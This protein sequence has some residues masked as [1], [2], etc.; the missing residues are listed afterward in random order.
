MLK[1]AHENRTLAL[2]F[3]IVG[4]ETIRKTEIFL[5]FLFLCMYIVTM[6]AH[7][8]IIGLVILDHQLHKPMYM[9][10]ANFSVAEIFYISTTMP[11]MLDA[12]L[13][14]N[15]EISY[16]GCIAQFY[17]FFSFG[18]TEHCF[19]VVMGYDRYVAICHPLHYYSMMAK[20]IS[21]G[22]A[23]GAWT[24]GLLAAAAPALWVSSLNFC[25]PNL[26]DHF[27]CDYAPLLKLSCEDT[28]KGEFTFT[29]IS[30]SVILGCF[31]LTLVS[32][33][34]IIFSVLKIPSVEGQKKAFSTCASHIIVV[35]IFD[36]TVIFMYIR[37]T[38][39]IRFTI[40]KVVSIFY[41]TVTPLLN[42]IIY[43]LRNKDVKN[44]LY[45]GLQWF[46]I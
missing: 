44:A 5:F 33:A 34:F 29:V 41:S 8:L 1:A 26:I 13:T 30:W 14:R 19:L 38:S 16:S 12:L 21:H 15:K 28:S 7:I 36:G 27:F 17:G 42:P 6:A 2:S 43:C 9:F 23:I 46:G 35:S 39:N 25:Y 3:I 45:K 37:P 24:G 32:Y 40:D 18:A 4:F 10:L 22:L 31:L 20:K 11:K